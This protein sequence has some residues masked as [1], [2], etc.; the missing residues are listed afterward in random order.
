MLLQFLWL[1]VVL[2]VTPFGLSK[3]KYLTNK[4]LKASLR[5]N[6]ELLF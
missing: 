6:G 3:R 1:L 4:E 5:L 2:M